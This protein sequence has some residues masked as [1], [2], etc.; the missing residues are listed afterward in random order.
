[1]LESGFVS[2]VI[3]SQFYPTSDFS[4]TKNI[5]FAPEIIKEYWNESLVWFKVW[6][7]FLNERNLADYEILGVVF[8]FNMSEEILAKSAKL[9][10]FNTFSTFTRKYSSIAQLVRVPDC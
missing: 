8:I 1:M 9:F 10:G 5:I 2:N 4:H 3:I 7:M 6:F